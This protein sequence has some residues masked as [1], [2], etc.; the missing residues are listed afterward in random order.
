MFMLYALVVGAIVGWIGGGRVSG[1]GEFRVRWAPLAVIGLLVQVV[2]F[3]GPIAER[4][5]DLGTAI[6]VGSTALVLVVVLRNVRVGGLALVAVGAISN[7][8]AIVANGGSMPASP[9]ALAVLDKGVNAG[10]SNSVV[11]TEPALWA[12]TDIFA[13]PHPFPF[14]NVF[15]VGDILIGIGIAGAV[16]TGM[17]MGG[18]SR[19]LHPRYSHPSTDTR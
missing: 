7:L 11:M 14:A 8:V 2:L 1:L 6:Y 17:R 3:F 16:A 10:Y 9:A 4:V 12:L 15:S 5:G 13:L 19:N 18:A